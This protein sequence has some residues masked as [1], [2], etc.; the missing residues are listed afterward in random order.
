MNQIDIDK[1]VKMANLINDVNKLLALV[2]EQGISSVGE[3]ELY[4]IYKTAKSRLLR[5]IG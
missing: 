5:I 2:E 1:L 4:S 3:A